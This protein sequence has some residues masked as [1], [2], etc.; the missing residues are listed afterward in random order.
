MK[1]SFFLLVNDWVLFVLV[2]E[3]LKVKIVFGYWKCIILW[4]VVDIVV[5]INS[6]NNLF[7]NVF[8]FFKCIF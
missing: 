3:F 8:I 4:L 7:V 1:L 5:V 6:S 2:L